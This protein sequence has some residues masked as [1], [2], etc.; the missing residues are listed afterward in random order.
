MNVRLDHWLILKEWMVSVI[1]AFSFWSWGHEILG[2][3]TWFFW[4]SVSKVS[5]YNFSDSSLILKFWSVKQAIL[6]GHDYAHLL[7]QH[8]LRRRITNSSQ[9]GLK[10]NQMAILQDFGKNLLFI[11]QFK[12]HLKIKQIKEITHYCL[13]TCIASLA[14]NTP[15]HRY[16][17]Y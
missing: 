13:H 3:L 5:T 7:F 2:N 1:N 16:T 8:F 9:P 12:V 17:D 4:E 11:D 14:M 15:H 6:A 10:T